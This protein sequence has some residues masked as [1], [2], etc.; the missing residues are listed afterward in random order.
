MG[1]EEQDMWGR[2]GMYV[3][4]DVT[5]GRNWRW[6]WRPDA[7]DAEDGKTRSDASGRCARASE[8]GLIF[9]D[10]PLT[11]DIYRCRDF[12]LLFCLDL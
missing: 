1:G 5:L 6:E 7:G 3:R 9:A 11:V 4:S 12:P 8:A 10:A 2:G